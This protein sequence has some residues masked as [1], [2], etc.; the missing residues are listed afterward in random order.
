M[1][2]GT[3]HD[4][5]ALDHRLLHSLAADDAVREGLAVLRA[6]GE[7]VT[8]ARRHVIEVLAASPDHL[9][10]DEVASRLASANVHRATVYRTLDL[11]VDA[12]VVS[13]RR[14]ANGATRYHLSTVHGHLHGHCRE[15]D[16]VVILPAD[17][18]D[19]AIARLREETG[20]DLQPDYATFEGL[21]GDCRA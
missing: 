20:F 18:F 8:D 7:R 21:C 9:T 19:D 4:V 6:R 11:L 1:A 3:P 13:L 5:D 10:A 17:A 12:D 15:C 2:Q 14:S 16:R